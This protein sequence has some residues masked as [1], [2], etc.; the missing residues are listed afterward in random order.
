M[1][2]TG[3]RKPGSGEGG[4]IEE[5]FFHQYASLVRKLALW[6]LKKQSEDGKSVLQPAV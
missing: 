5:S 6:E 1:S 3:E 4:S 2:T